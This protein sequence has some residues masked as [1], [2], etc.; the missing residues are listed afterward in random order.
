MLKLE[1]TSSAYENAKHSPEWKALF[2]YKETFIL[3]T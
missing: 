2:I 3:L 1:Q